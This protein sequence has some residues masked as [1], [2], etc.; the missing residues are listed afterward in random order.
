MIGNLTGD[1]EVR[2]T[3]SG[4][5]VANF[6]VA[7]TER[8]RVNGEWT[9]GDTSFFR[10]A[11]WDQ[12]GVN[13]AASLVKGSR[14]IV[15]GKLTVRDY[16]VDGEKRVSLDVAADEVGAALRYASATL[17]RVAPVAAAPAA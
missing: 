14:V 1:P 17:V 12:Y 16:E 2:T 9:D 15:L 11:V 13:V 6:S 7:S 3:T 10:V 4:K 5:K 8:V